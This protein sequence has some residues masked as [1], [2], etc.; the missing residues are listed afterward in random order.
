MC[1]R[2]EWQRYIK[3][4]NDWVEAPSDAEFNRIGR[5][6]WSQHAELLPVIGTAGKVLRPIII[7]NRVHNVPTTL[8]FAWET[9]PWVATTP[10]QWFIRE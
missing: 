10:M 6:V 7:N 5:E 4:R 8:T 1:R 2:P 3:A 9:T